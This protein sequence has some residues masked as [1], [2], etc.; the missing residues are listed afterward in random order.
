MVH[1]NTVS[2]GA[3][4]PSC[5]LNVFSMQGCLHLF[6]H[7]LCTRNSLTLSAHIYANPHPNCPRALSVTLVYFYTFF[8]VSFVSLHF[9]SAV[10]Y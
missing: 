8:S 3:D 5:K 9:T 2:E 4:C 1:L 6:A 7:L 10:A